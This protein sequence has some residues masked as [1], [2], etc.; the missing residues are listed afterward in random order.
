VE[1]DV[2]KPAWRIDVAEYQSLDSVEVDA[3][4]MQRS[5]RGGLMLLNIE[6][7]IPK[8]GF[9]GGGCNEAGVLL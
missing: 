6:A 1:V 8:L 4:I 5:R 2:T 9:R 7:W 3:R